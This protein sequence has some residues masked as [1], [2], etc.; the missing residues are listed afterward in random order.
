[1]RRNWIWPLQVA[2]LGIGLAAVPHVQ[3]AA[4]LAGLWEFDDPSHPLKAKRG[5]D[6]VVVGTAPVRLA[7]QIDDHG[8]ALSGVIVTRSGAAHALRALHQIPANG[9]G[10]R[11]NQYSILLDLYSPAASRGSWRALFQTAAVP[12]GNDADYL[13]RNSDDRL[14]VGDMG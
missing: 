12:T 14:G 4:Q 13:I 1:M 5:Q 10:N 11:V 9:G 3:A 8:T 2:V 7:S 6:L